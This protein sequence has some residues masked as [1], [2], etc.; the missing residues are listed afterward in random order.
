[1][2]LNFGKKFKQQLGIICNKT[3][4]VKISDETEDS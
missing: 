2:F 3:V 4:Q 1:M